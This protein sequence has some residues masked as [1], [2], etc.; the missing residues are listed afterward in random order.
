M[1]T[2][3]VSGRAGRGIFPASG[4]TK[5]G[6]V[7]DLERDIGEAI[8]SDRISFWLD[9]THAPMRPALRADQAAD[10]LVIGAGMAGLMTAVLLAKAGRSVVVVEAGAVAAGVSGFTTAKVTVGH[11]LV[12]SRLQSKFDTAT[13]RAYADSQTAGLA[14]IRTL[15]HEHAIECDLETRP[16]YVVA[17][18]E[19]ERDAI[20]REAE[21]ARSAGLDARVGT[22]QNPI[23][24]GPA[25]MLPDQAQFHVRKYLLRLAGLVVELG[26]QIFE[27]S[28]VTDI[29]GS[30]PYRARTEHGAVRAADVVVATHYPIVEQGFFSTRIHPRRS[31][32]VAAPLNEIV[33][34]GMFIGTS[35]PSRSSRTVPLA[36]GRQLLLVGGEGHRVGQEADMPGRYAALEADMRKHFSVG[37]TSYRWSTQDNFSVD[38]LPYIGP[39][40]DHPGLYAATGFAGWG[41]TN[42]AVAAIVISDAIT[43]RETA[44][45]GLYDLDRSHVIAAARSFLVDNTNVARQQIS[46]ALHSPAGPPGDLAAGQGA[47]VSIDNEDVA[48][49]RD[50]EGR[51]H[52]V[53]PS[54]THMGCTVTWNL[55]E[56][57][58]DCPCHGSR[59][60]ADGRVLHGPAVSPLEPASVD[61]AHLARG[62]R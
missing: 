46:D 21:A 42:G 57:T 48:L 45:V 50:G 60:A 43:G 40:P 61:L 26:G 44:W 36:D 25:V 55:A 6:T 24:A 49:S 17:T 41:M 37:E 59:F 35:S 56:A 52:A 9:S 3:E 13:A 27:H 30:G 12:Y 11:G 33:P 31:Y 1:A 38:G 10:V 19:D 18:S 39:V 51:L 58:W 34:D 23:T 62:V 28:R 32:I 4:P 14:L 16:N 8:R 20:E 2:A 53:S 54:C 5:G 7:P 22:A 29:S 15:C 47:V